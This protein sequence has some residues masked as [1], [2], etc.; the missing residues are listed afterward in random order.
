MDSGW[1]IAVDACARGGVGGFSGDVQ[2]LGGAWSLEFGVGWCI[3][4]ISNQGFEIVSTLRGWE[5][6]LL[7]YWLTGTKFSGEV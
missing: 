6:G 7:I 5:V 4:T 2:Q 1:W 3:S